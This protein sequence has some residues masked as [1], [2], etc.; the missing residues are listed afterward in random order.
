LYSHEFGDK[1]LQLVASSIKNSVRK[2]DIIGR[3]GGEEFLIYIPY[4]S[5]VDAQIIANRICS[6]LRQQRILSDRT[7]TVTIGIARYPEDSIFA[8]MLISKADIACRFGKMNGKNQVVLYD[9]SISISSMSTSYLSGILV[10][11]PIQS[12][13]NVR[14]IV[15]LIELSKN[16]KISFIEKCANAMNLIMKA[17]QSEY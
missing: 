14:I 1:V 13:E 15:E 16:S 10:R 17:I 5:L 9:P 6:T 4:I 2:V 11:D 7:I 3:Y 12:S 8:D